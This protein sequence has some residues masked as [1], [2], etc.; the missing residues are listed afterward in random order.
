M[1]YLLRICGGKRY[2]SQYL[3]HIKQLTKDKNINICIEAVKTLLEC[4]I[5]YGPSFLNQ[6]LRSKNTDL[7]QKAVM[8]SRTYKVKEAAPYLIE[9]LKKKDPFGT[10]SY[11]KI[12]VV[13]AL[14]EIGDPKAIEP[15]TK[16]YKSK[17][18]FYKGVLDEL[19]EEIFRTVKSYPRIALGPLLE[20]GKNSG[21]N[22]I[23]SVC[24]EL[25]SETSAQGNKEQ[26]G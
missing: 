10:E 1:I 8:L 4:G 7:Q 16:L 20:L 3:D 14:A 21:N 5:Y 12:P 25:L 6:C 18:L 2:Q 26:V 23:K 15:L 17:T 9:L 19:K 24:K 13:R 11:Y 22:Y